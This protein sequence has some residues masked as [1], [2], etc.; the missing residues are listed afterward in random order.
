MIDVLLQ[1]GADINARSHWWAGSFGVLDSDSELTPFLIER[2]AVVDMHAAARL[3]RMDRLAELVSA[4]PHLVHA[5]GGD[6]QTPL[7]FAA[8]TAVA[9][10]LLQH[11]ANIDALDVDHEST[12]AQYMVRDRP[13]VA[14]HLVARGC[15]TD[16]FLAAALGDRGL[17]ERHLEADP[18]CLRLDISERCFPKRDPRA[19]GTIYNWTLGAH[20]TPHAVAR[21]FGHDDLFQL[22]I[23]RSP[24]ELQRA[25]ACEVGDEALLQKLLASR[26]Q[27]PLNLSDD[28]QRKLAHAAQHNH[29]TAVR[30]LL[31]AGW[32]VNVRGQH[33]ATPLHWAAFHGNAE[34]AKILLNYHPDLEALDAEY[35][36]TPL[37]WAIYGSEESWHRRTGDYAATVEALLAAGAKS[38][39]KIGGTSAVQNVLRRFG[40]KDEA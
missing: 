1:S 17:V 15:R 19:G 14:R 26:P 37:G 23:A 39:K 35:H 24:E 20:K 38:P 11:G 31:V 10:Y 32:P 21:E 25:V 16:I 8:S 2:G 27:R 30:L 4:N 33:G 36:G 18:G 28:E 5:R 9:D 22:L 12:P 13:D 34:M 40:A 6:G 29:T 7:H 3:G